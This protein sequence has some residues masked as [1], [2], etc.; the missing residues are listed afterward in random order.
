MGDTAPSSSAHSHCIMNH[1]AFSSW[2]TDAALGS[3]FLWILV[4]L[5]SATEPNSDPRGIRFVC[6]THSWNWHLGFPVMPVPGTGTLVPSRYKCIPY[7]GKI[8][9]YSSD[10]L[11]PFFFKLYCLIIDIICECLDLESSGSL[12]T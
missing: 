3:L 12:L 2:G 11:G 4:N 1:P 5:V 7:S 10:K 9:V 6:S 8:I